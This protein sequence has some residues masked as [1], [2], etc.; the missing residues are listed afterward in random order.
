MLIVDR[1]AGAMLARATWSQMPTRRAILLASTIIVCCVEVSA[2][3]AQNSNTTL[4]PVE[5]QAPEKRKLPSRPRSRTQSAVAG[6]R[7]TARSNQAP[8]TTSPTASAGGTGGNGANDGQSGSPLQ[9]TPALGKTG[10]KLEDL[11]VSVQIIQRRTL[12]EQGST[13]LR[14]AITNA[15]GINEGGQDSLGYFD[16]FLIRGLNAQVYSDGFSDG[17]LL[18]GLSHSLNGVQRIEILEGPGSALFG[19]GPP[20]GTI[21]VVHYAPS[22]VLHYGS[23]LQLGSFGTVTNSDYITGPTT[24]EGLNYRLDALFSRADGFRDLA[25]QDYEVR[26]EFTWHVGDHTLNF[27]L[28]AWHLNQTP[29]SYGLI[30]FNGS[31][32]TGVPN[33][34]K[35]SRR[36][37]MLIRISFVRR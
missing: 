32:I 25:S 34:A 35:Y 18:G 12:D 5:V 37:P 11:P 26:P 28:D 27:A 4:P 1:P 31:P 20:G 33:T 22:P 7:R 24:I 17:D 8:K 2:A 16:H 23:S 36:S 19:S 9:Q 6:K 10:T 13:S 21:N 29:D 3:R 14:T 15:S 30:Y